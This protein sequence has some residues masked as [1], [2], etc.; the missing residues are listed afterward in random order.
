MS[1]FIS[2]LNKNHIYKV[3]YV[4]GRNKENYLMEMLGKDCPKMVNLEAIK[5]CV[6]L[7]KKNPSM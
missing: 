2:D 4:K 5:D 1:S 7:T 6:K 3:L